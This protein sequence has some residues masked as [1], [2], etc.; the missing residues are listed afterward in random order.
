MAQ[1]QRSDEVLRIN[2]GK[3]LRTLRK[4]YGVTLTD[5][6]S[7]FN[8][9]HQ[10]WYKYEM[11]TN[12]ISF[13]K[14]LKFAD[15]FGGITLFLRMLEQPLEDTVS[16]HR[17]YKLVRNCIKIQNL[18]SVEILYRMSESLIEVEQNDNQNDTK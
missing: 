6:S 15:N 5:C 9:T 1:K 7:L 12:N 17:T 13:D 14:I 3:V 8:V 18:K 2:V 10:Q 4:A 11:G 16:E